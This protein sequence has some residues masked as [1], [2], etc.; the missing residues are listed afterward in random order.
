MLIIYIYS[1]L[2]F[3]NHFQVKNPKHRPSI[4]FLL[5]HSA[6]T[7]LPESASDESTALNNNEKSPSIY[8]TPEGIE[9]GQTGSSCLGKRS[10]DSPML[11]R[12]E[13]D[14]PQAPLYISKFIDNHTYTG[15]LY[16]SSI[17]YYDKYF[18]GL[19]YLM[20]NGDVG[21]WK[22]GGFQ[23][24][25]HGQ[26]KSL[27]IRYRGEKWETIPEWYYNDNPE[28]LNES[29]AEIESMR[30]GMGKLQNAVTC[31]RG[32]VAMKPPIHL[33]HVK[34][35]GLRAIVFFFS[36]GDYQVNFL[37]PASKRMKIIGS[38]VSFLFSFC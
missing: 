9:S 18:L 1:T 28:C 3:T 14:N 31:L 5:R 20:S 36:N 16:R 35:L 23:V 10:R 38:K 11:P 37:E 8:F 6:V 17:T 12:K 15:E 7:N 33:V 27:E 21:V 4:D 26:D 25:E 32:R 13:Q 2:Y 19:G 30:N 34:R 22:A 29:L 24:L